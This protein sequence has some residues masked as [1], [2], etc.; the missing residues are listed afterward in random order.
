MPFCCNL[1]LPSP[2]FLSAGA[3]GGD[4]RRQIAYKDVP[5]SASFICIEHLSCEDAPNQRNES[6]DRS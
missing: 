4:I 6:G 2:S 1:F 5:S 3:A